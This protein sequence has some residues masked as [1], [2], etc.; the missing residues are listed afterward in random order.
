MEPHIWKIE[1]ND[2]MS[3]GIPEVDENHKRFAS[4]VNDFNRAIV[5]R[6]ELDEIKKRLQLIIA[7]ASR[8]FANE[9]KLFREWNYP[10]LQ[11]HIGKHAQIIQALQDIKEKPLNYNLYS[12]WI[13]AGLAIKDVLIGHI[14]NEDIK[15]ADYY[16]SKIAGSTGKN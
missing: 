13:E 4:L 10:D 9:A 6:M 14:L 1:W 3:V 8:H 16:R 15:Y 5:D 11:D 12:E 7:D 2:R